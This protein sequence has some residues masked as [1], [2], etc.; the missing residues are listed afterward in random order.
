MAINTT[1]K[2]RVLSILGEDNADYLDQISAP[3]EIWNE[4]LWEVAGMVPHRYLLTQV[5]SP[6]DPENMITSQQTQGQPFEADDKIVLL[7]MRIETDHI[8]SGEGVLINEKYVTKPCKEIPFEKI[9]K[10]K[11]INSIFYATQHSPVFV[12][13][14]IQGKRNLFV[15]PAV[16]T[17]WTA[18]TG[19][20]VDPNIM[21]L[22]NSALM[23]FAYERETIMET[24]GETET[25]SAWDTMTDFKN[26]P[27][28]VEDI[29]IKRIALK[30][31]ELKMSHMATQEEDTELYT[32]LAQDKALLEESLL[33]SI[34]KLNKD[35]GVSK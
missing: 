24:G 28:D 15:Y 32:L 35:W 14:N 16:S 7:V 8:T 31:I 12:Y 29:I 19:P 5:P 20:Y 21:P 17:P 33:E 22:G 34:K 13:K 9:D 25:D 11:N 10:V 30:I 18:G 26:I 3:E 4:A 23:I 2:A 27:R 1:T 6:I